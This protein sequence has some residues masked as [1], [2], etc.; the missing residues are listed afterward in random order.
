[1]PEKYACH[2][3]GYLTLDEPGGDSYDICPVCWWED[4]P[5]Q[6][7]DPDYGGGANTESLNQARVNFKAFGASREE[8]LPFVRP[9]LPTELPAES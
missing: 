1:M 9:P 5:V 7:K 2:C 3:C 8:D 4:D 6:N